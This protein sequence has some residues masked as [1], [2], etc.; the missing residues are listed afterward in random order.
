M[1]EMLVKHSICLIGWLRILMDLRLVILIL[2]SQPP[3]YLIMLPPRCEIC[4]CSDHDNSSYP[5]HIS[6]DS[7]PILGSMIEIMNEQQVK[8]VNNLREYNLS[9]GRPYV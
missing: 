2:T 1:I 7:F 8:F 3:A 6:A 4:H 5:Y 9:H